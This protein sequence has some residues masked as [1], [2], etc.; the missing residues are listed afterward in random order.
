[1]II[2]PAIDIKDG[3]CVRLVQGDFN[4]VTEYGKDPVKQAII[5]EKQ[6]AK[7]IHIVDLDGSREGEAKILDI[8][9]KMSG[10]VS[11]PIQVGGGMRTLDDIEQLLNS[12]ATRVI[13]GTLAVKEPEIVKEAVIKWGNRI[14]VGIDS[15]EGMV[16]I[17]GW[18]ETSK[19]EAVELAKKMEAIGV[20]T[21]IYTDISRDGML[22]GPN[23]EAMDSMS[24]AVNIDVIASGGVSKLKDIV[25]LS[26][27]NVEGVIVGKALYEGK[28]NLK[29]AIKE[30]GE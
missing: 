22:T 15:K 10:E 3:K 5:W 9:K 16:A 23:I 13:L 2:Y 12:G 26:K 21:I 19:M 8:I 30:L 7:Y 11:V 14:V 24:K 20:K 29:E 25:S 28:F 18:E 17:Q 27:I 1:M 4:R 6:G